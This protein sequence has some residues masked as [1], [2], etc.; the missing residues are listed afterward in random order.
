MTVDKDDMALGLL[1]KGSYL[2][3][4]SESPGEE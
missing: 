1:D 4:T 3:W 2:R